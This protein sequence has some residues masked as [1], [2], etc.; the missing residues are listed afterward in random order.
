MPF[1]HSCFIS[2]CHGQGDV[3][4]PFIEQLKAGLDSYLEPY[5]DERVYID[6]ERLK[7]GY[8]FNAALAHAL[9]E[10]ICMIVVYVPRYERHPYCLQE[11]AAMEALETARLAALGLGEEEP[12]GLIIPIILRGRG[13]ELPARIRE[14]RHYA[15]FSRFTTASPDIRRNDEYARRL[16][17]I[18]QYI[19]DMYQRFAAAGTDLCRDCASFRL[20][21][22]EAVRPWRH[23]GAARSEPFPFR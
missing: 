19:H 13:H 5:L 11:F 3:I 4:R 22:A 14:H 21:A 1:K 16:D 15:D 2:Y 9:C 10:S 18:A 12:L 17:D 20:P 7:P 8:R 23:D 6:E